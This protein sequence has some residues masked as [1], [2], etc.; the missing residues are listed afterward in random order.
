[1]RSHD[2]HVESE[3]LKSASLVHDRIRAV[4]DTVIVLTFQMILRATLMMRRWNY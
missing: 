4:R 3:G 2:E 1:M